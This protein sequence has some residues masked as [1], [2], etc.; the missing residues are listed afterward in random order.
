MF[1]QFYKAHA[2]MLVDIHTHNQC[3]S[4]YRSIINLNIDDA[5]SILTSKKYELFSIGLHPWHINEN[6]AKE[7]LHLEKSI[8]N[9][10]LIL[11]LV[12]NICCL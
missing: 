1:L 9:L 12:L 10:L 2:S 4:A 8:F 6:S 7:I 3:N 11:M 5:L